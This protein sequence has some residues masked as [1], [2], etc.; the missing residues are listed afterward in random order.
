MVYIFYGYSYIVNFKKAIEHAYTI[1][2]N[3]IIINESIINY[4]KENIE[5]FL[6]Y[7]SLPGSENNPSVIIIEHP[8]NIKEILIQLFLFY[9]ENMPKF[10]TIILVT[11]QLQKIQKTIIS[12]SILILN[13][14]KNEDEI[15]YTKFI[16]ELQSDLLTNKSIESIID[17][18]DIN[19]KNTLNASIIL[20]QSKPHLQ[21]EINNLL[22]K[23]LTFIKNSHYL[24]WKMI[25]LILHRK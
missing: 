19:E 9:F 3:P 22:K 17:L 24:Y 2:Q 23:Q 11:N 16:N 8:E 7:F 12:R 4:S 15:K 10:N 18:Y 21:L 6:Y 13:Q 20:L 25:F 5:L 14:E 1:T